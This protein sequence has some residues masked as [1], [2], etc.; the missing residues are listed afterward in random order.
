M[1]EALLAG[2]RF[3]NHTSKVSDDCCVFQVLGRSVN[4]N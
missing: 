2:C 1:K 4:G 3:F